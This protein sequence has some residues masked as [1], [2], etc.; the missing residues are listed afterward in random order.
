MDYAVFKRTEIGNEPIG[1]LGSPGK[2][3]WVRNTAPYFWETKPFKWS[4]QFRGEQVTGSFNSCC[5]KFSKLLPMRIW[6][7]NLLS[8]RKQLSH[9][10]KVLFEKMLEIISSICKE[11]LASPICT[12]NF[13]LCHQY[14]ERTLD[15]NKSDQ[16]HISVSQ[17]RKFTTRQSERQCQ[18]P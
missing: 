3:G 10:T 13:D 7:N 5:S 9:P 8:K 12:G 14:R 1:I 6:W 2:L 15:P 11:T 16:H 17:K 4:I 18:W